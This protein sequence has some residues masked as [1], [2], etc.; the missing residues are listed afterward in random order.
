MTQ[1]FD[2]ENRVV[3]VTV[4]RVGGCR[5]GQVKTVDNDGYA[6][7]QLFFGEKRRGTANKPDGGH[8]KKLGVGAPRHIIEMRIDDGDEFSPG[9]QIT[10]DIFEAGD[11]VDAIGVSK[12]KGHTGV[13]KRHNFKG[14]R[15]SHGVHR[16]HRHG[17]SIGMAAT[18]SRVIKGMKMSG[19]HGHARTT[20]QNLRVVSAD[21]DR[22][23][24]L[25]AGALPGPNGGLVML[26]DPAK[27]AKTN[28]GK[29]GK[30]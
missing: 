25:I 3:P 26:K 21:V 15:A 8:A 19:H 14:Q 13:M 20:V 29:G 2:E 4:V 27:G 22:E 7:V 23:L 1:I 12:G 6:A 9:Q 16:V 18:P 17:G 30:R 28:D 5:V 11:I 10:A 24:I